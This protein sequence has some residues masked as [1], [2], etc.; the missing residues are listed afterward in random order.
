M[1]TLIHRM[2]IA[3]MSILASAS[4]FAHAG[5]DHGHWTSGV[6]HTVFYVALASVAAA[7]S[8]SAY[9]YINR[10]KNARENK[11]CEHIQI[12]TTKNKKQTM[13]EQS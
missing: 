12:Q 11:H 8:Y 4:A 5:H 10:K 7:C 6:L 2:C 3:I 1:N 9:K 13:K